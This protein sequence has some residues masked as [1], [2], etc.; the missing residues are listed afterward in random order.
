MISL[1]DLL[2]FKGKWRWSESAGWGVGDWEKWREGKV[3]L[4]Y[5][6]REN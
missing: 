6:V 2:F 5:S 4:V 3:W 1:R